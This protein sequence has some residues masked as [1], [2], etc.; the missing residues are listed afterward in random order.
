MRGGEALDD[1]ISDILEHTE[2]EALLE[3]AENSSS[4]KRTESG[5]SAD[6]EQLM[7]DVLPDISDCSVPA[8][9]MLFYYLGN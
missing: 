1:L 8:E 7:G 3:A 2:K 4:L 6:W 9:H 5:P